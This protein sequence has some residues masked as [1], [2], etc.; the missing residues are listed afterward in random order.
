MIKNIKLIIKISYYSK[1][2]MRYFLVH[3][4]NKGGIKMPMF[5]VTVIAF[6]LKF[7]QPIYGYRKDYAENEIKEIIEKYTRETKGKLRA[8]GYIG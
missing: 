7:R 1:V 2:N 5:Y 4:S 3:N 6:G 8:L